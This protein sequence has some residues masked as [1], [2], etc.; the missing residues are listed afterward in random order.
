MEQLIETGSEDMAARFTAF[1]N[2]DGNARYQN[3]GA[4]PHEQ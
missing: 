2:L 4:G 3:L 1:V